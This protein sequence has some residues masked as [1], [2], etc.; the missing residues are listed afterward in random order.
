L[1]F[2]MFTLNTG[3]FIPNIKRFYNENLVCPSVE[4][5]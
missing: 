2:C 3:L 1:S 5:I 4:A